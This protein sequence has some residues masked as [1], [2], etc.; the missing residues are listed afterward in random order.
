M[1]SA[2][3]C[4]WTKRLGNV[5]DGRARDAV[6]PEQVHPFVARA[7]G[8]HRLDQRDQRV[9]VGERAG[10]L[11]KR[12]SSIHSG[13]P[14]RRARPATARRQRTRSSWVRCRWETPGRARWS[15]RRCRRAGRRGRSPGSSQSRRRARTPRSLAARC[16]PRRPL[17]VLARRAGR[18]VWRSPPTCRR[19]CRRCRRA[20]SSGPPLGLAVDCCIR[21]QRLG[22]PVIGAPAAP[23][24]LRAIGADRAVDQARVERQRLGA[25]ETDRLGSARAQVVDEHVGLRDEALERG[26]VLG[27]LEVE[28]HRTLVAV[29]RLEATPWPSSRAAPSRARRRRRSGSRA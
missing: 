19:P 2:W 8:E 1:P 23:R 12:G 10:L 29:D 11:A 24:A 5:E 21:G 18:R 22:E 7:G 15:R 17:P 25:A 9:A 28:R 3:L 6:G 14:S 13:R 16:R 20:P 27:A 26:D 4:G